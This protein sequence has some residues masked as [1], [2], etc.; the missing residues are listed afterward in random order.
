RL[1]EYFLPAWRNE[2]AAL[3][4]GAS[5]GWQRTGYSIVTWTSPVAAG[6]TPP[7]DLTPVCRLYI[8]PIDG[9]SHFYSVSKV[10][11]AAVPA[12][13]PEVFFETDAAFF[14]TLPN[15]QTGACP[16]DQA[17]VY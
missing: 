13:H 3:A 2:S 8:P 6:Q 15:L 10:E 16:P 4:S 11:C 14:A 1:D 12:Q 17:P 9:D 7:A 5:P